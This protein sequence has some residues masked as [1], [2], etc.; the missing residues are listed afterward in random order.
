[1]RKREEGAQRLNW[2]GQNM[3]KTEEDN[4]SMKWWEWLYWGREDGQPRWRCSTTPGKM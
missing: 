1:M 3:R 2:H 4:L